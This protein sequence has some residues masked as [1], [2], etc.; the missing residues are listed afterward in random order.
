[1]QSLFLI[2]SYLFSR[3]WNSLSLSFR[4]SSMLPKLVEAFYKSLL[5]HFAYERQSCKPNKSNGVIMVPLF[6][7]K[8]W[9]NVRFGWCT[10]PSSSAYLYKNG[11]KS[12]LFKFV[13]LANWSKYGRGF[14]QKLLKLQKSFYCTNYRH[15]F[16]LFKN[17]SPPKSLLKGKIPSN[18]VSLKCVTCL[19]TTSHNPRT[20][21]FCNSTL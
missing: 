6:T 12:C 20:L 2:A 3:F 10:S 5:N 13:L 9:V 1:M 7:S 21:H 18:V 16:E 14:Y 11:L 19:M 4:L 15:L 17:W 8:L